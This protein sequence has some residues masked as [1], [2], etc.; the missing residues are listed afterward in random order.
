MRCHVTE[1]IKRNPLGGGDL[2]GETH[3]GETHWGGGETHWG[4]V[5][6]MLIF[7]CFY[8]KLRIESLNPDRYFSYKYHKSQLRL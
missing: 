7:Y 4:G 2:G 5:K 1:M 6:A 8:F 3:G